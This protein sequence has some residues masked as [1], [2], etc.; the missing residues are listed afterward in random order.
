VSSPAQKL[1][2]AA[3][4]VIGVVILGPFMTQM[5]S[6]VVNVSLPAIKESLHSS[7]SLSQWI[8]TCYLLALALM[9]PLNAWLVDRFGAKK[10][11]LLCFFF[12]T[13][14]SGLCAMAVSMPE[15]I[16]ARVVQGI[17][18]GLL[19]PLTQLMM[20]RVAGR[21]LA[22][23]AGYAAVPILFAPLVGP[24]LAGLILQH[25]GWPWLFYVNLPVGAAAI[26][27]AAWWLP[28][29]EPGTQRHPFDLQG[30]A[31][32]SPGLVCL[33]YGLET[34]S[35]GEPGAW[36]LIPGVCLCLLFGWHAARSGGRALVEFDLFKIRVF[37][38]ATITMFLGNG[39]LY[40]G[41]FLIPL[42]LTLGCHLSA[43]QAGWILSSMGLG[44]LCVYP[45]IGWLTDAFG[46]RAV[47]SSGVALNFAGTLPFV[48]M[49]THEFSTPLAIF[50]LMIRGLSQGA[51]GLPSIAAAYAAVPKSKL[52]LATM[53]VNI[54]QRLG[55]PMVTTLIAIAVSF[56]VGVSRVS[57]EAFLLPFAALTGVQ[58]LVIGTAVRLPVR[59]H[60]EATT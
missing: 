56:S 60:S 46:C 42:Y 2:A 31:L 23:V 48:W 52:G 3:W 34:A 43:S 50:G 38:Y 19:A 41:Q 6:T 35:R 27:L 12:F 33:L 9:L 17:A 13:V 32:I 30:F 45:F 8:I 16:A 40:A 29:D 24:L 7:V 55:G 51:T 39:I 18:G 22:R 15:L 11:Y 25:L 26:V 59:I 4:K 21:Q 14:A 28:H 54:I 10:L 47:V 37:S 57:Q 5:D 36:A 1:G 49:A 53:T 58:L 20:A 44:M